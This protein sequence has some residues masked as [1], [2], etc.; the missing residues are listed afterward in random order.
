M[1]LR[2]P[3]LIDSP[4]R[5]AHALAAHLAHHNAGHS[6]VGMPDPSPMD[7]LLEWVRQ[8]AVRAS[9]VSIVTGAAIFAIYHH[10]GDSHAASRGRVLALAGI[11][12]VGVAALGPTL[13]SL[14]HTASA[15]AT[16][17]AR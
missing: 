16:G 10:L 15:A 3:H 2:S 5:P 12:G 14:L 11:V 17:T 7:T 6:T 1:L 13:G 4:L 9:V 8:L